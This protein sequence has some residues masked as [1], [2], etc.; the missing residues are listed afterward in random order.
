MSQVVRL[1]WGLREGNTYPLL[2]ETECRAGRTPANDIILD[3]DPMTSAHH[4]ILRVRQGLLYLMD[5]NSTNG[6]VCE[7]IR[8]AAKEWH[9]VNQFFVLGAS[10]FAVGSRPNRV[11]KQP[12]PVASASIWHP[13]P[14][15]KAALDFS[16]DMPFLGAAHLFLALCKQDSQIVLPFLERINVALDLPAWQNALAS[17]HLFKASLAWLTKPLEIGARPGP[18][19]KVITPLAQTLFQGYY[20][21]PEPAALLRQFLE[22]DFNMVH[23]LLQWPQ[24]Q[25]NW[26]IALNEVARQETIRKT[27]NCAD[28]ALQE[29]LIYKRLWEE[30]AAISANH[31][32]PVI[33]GSSGTGKSFILRRMAQGATRSLLKPPLKA[34][35]TRLI[36][37]KEFL[38][39]NPP[40]MLGRYFKDLKQD[41]KTEGLVMLDHIDTLIQTIIQYDFDLL[42]LATALET[43]KPNLLLVCHSDSLPILRDQFPRIQAVDLDEYLKPNLDILHQNMLQWFQQELGGTLSEATRQFYLNQIV[44]RSPLDLR[45]IKEFLDICLLRMRNLGSMGDLSDSRTTSFGRLGEHLMREVYQ[46]WIGPEPTVNKPQK[47]SQEERVL[48]EIERFLFQFSI[49]MTKIPLR[50]GPSSASF[51][52]VSNLP[53]EHKLEML[54]EHVLKV[55][56]TLKLGFRDWFEAYWHE[57]SPDGLKRKVGTNERKLWHEYEEM[58]RRIDWGSAEEQMREA[59]KNRLS[60]MKQSDLW[61]I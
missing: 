21:N 25:A 43:S 5:L 17:G 57:T 41:L 60:N 49:P 40:K 24:T 33:A 10:V 35:P 1:I 59:C 26:S 14:L 39:Y 6:T 31:R 22:D 32:V 16:G 20:E 29:T 47:E 53:R 13:M 18:Q 28:S 52:D 38:L 7:G 55:M 27:T 37:P 34:E 44:A 50:Y 58:A 4:A 15:Y 8:L 11:I 48:L 61:K 3:H 12:L 54:K 56:A 45:R 30:L 23:A 36:D 9:R 46:A 42:D 19:P 2:E 51:A